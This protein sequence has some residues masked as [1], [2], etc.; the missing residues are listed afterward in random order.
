MLI[1]TYLPKDN[2]AFFIPLL[3]QL[4]Q[5]TKNINHGFGKKDLLVANF[6]P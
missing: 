6:H 3:L 5:L 2:S 1:F 4:S